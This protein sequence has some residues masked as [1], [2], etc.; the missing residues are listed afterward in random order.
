VRRIASA[1]RCREAEVAG[2]RPR[3]PAR[4]VSVADLLDTQE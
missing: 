2:F 1:R 4:A 3:F